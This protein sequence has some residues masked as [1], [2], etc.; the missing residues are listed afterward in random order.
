[1]MSAR[2]QLTATFVRSV[3]HSGARTL[4]GDRRE[5][6]TLR[7]DRH[8][9]GAHGLFL[10][11]M[12]TGSKQWCQRLS[13]DGK[14][15]IYGLGAY[16]F[17][18][19]AEARDQAFEN[20]R[21]AREYR[22][23][24]AR[25]ERPE[26]PA[27]ELNR[28]ATVARRN[29]RPV[30]IVAQQVAGITFAE[31]FEACIVSRAKHWKDAQTSLRSWRAD[32]RDHL[33]GLAGRKVAALTVDHLRQAL[34][35]LAPKTADKVLRRVG[36]VLDQAVADGHRLDNPAKVLRKTMAGLKRGEVVHRDALPYA[37]VPAFY[38]QLLAGGTGADARGA[39]ALVVLTGTRSG[40]GRLARWEEVDMD[41]RTWTVPAGRMKDGREHRVPL[42]EAA[43][44]VLRAAGP[45]ATGPVFRSPWGN[46]VSD[47]TLLRVLRTV[48]A[49]AG[50]E[51]KASV[52][53]FR[54]S[55]RDWC[56]E[57]GVA[58]EVAEAILAHRV[59]S[60][61]EQAYARSTVIERRRSALEAWGTHV[62]G[63]AA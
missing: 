14:R 24:V 28:L 55:L 44:A 13:L 32:L 62:T 51:A 23:S 48:L 17:T 30:P 18:T 3:R 9:D 11:V 19:L 38:K 6:G 16:P 61:V 22:R 7:A 56:A 27:F 20:E 53:G 50:I 46:D 63:G 5:A 35:P 49:E 52:H 8:H 10:Q 34:D 39:L 26:V 42:S 45:K 41:E 25:G 12:P 36:T 43:C 33:K 47:K 37:D 31:A 60:S 54:S 21:A 29:G 59:G 40:E 2:L 57:T 4:K 58:R 1:M 15:S